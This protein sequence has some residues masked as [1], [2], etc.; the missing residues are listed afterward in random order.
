MRSMIALAMLLALAI[1]FGVVVSAC[2]GAGPQPVSDSLTWDQGS[3]DT[4]KWQ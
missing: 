1:G 4:Y 2:S 3:W